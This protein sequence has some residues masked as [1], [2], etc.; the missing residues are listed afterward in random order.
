MTDDVPAWNQY[1]RHGLADRSPLRVEC[2]PAGHGEQE[3]G[4]ACCQR[5]LLDSP[6]VIFAEHK[7]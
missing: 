4:V 2:M 1:R 5:R 7:E 6:H 3:C